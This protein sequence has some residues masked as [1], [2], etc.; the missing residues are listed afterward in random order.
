MPIADCRLG[1]NFDDS[2]LV[3]SEFISPDTRLIPPRST[4]Q[5]R[6]VSQISRYFSNPQSPF[7]IQLKSI[8]TVFQ[9][10]VWQALSDIPVGTTLTYG[11]LAQNLNSSPRAVGNACRVNPIP[12]IVPC[13]RVV[14][15][16]GIGGFMGKR[17]GNE[18]SIKEC[19]LKHEQAQYGC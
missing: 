8:G 19:L 14:S 16:S 13:H 17:D 12:L 4:V 18:I 3:G 1:L 10:R 7:E 5:Q 11:A 9:K 2:L 15:A 6:L